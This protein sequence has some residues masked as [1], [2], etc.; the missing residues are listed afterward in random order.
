MLLSLFSLYMIEKYFSSLVVL[1]CRF[2]IHA[3][4][5][6]RF[7]TFKKLLG[8]LLVF[9]MIQQLRELI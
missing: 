5:H 9:K 8:K 6:Y 4:Y 1:F 3:E 7:Y 2:R